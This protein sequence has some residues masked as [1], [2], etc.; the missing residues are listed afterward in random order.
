V[1]NTV[2]KVPHPPNCEDIFLDRGLSLVNYPGQATPFHTS[3]GSK[4]PGAIRL[5]LFWHIYAILT[6]FYC[7]II[8]ILNLIV[9]HA[10][11]NLKNLAEIELERLE[12]ESNE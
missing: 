12:V 8:Q 2:L 10:N 11:D 6:L 9:E 1:R 4:G 7:Y 5:I 3:P